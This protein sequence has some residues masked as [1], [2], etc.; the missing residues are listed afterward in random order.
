LYIRRVAEP[1]KDAP[2]PR[3]LGR[4]RRSSEAR[5]AQLLDAAYDV[6]AAGGPP[7]GGMADVAAAAGVSAGL[8]YHY[9]PSGRAELIEALARRLLDE[10]CDRVEVAASL[11]FSALGRLEQA[12]A[13]LVG[14]LVDRPVAY[15][16]LF[17]GT[18]TGGDGELSR[19]AR[20][21]LVTLFTTHLA[22]SARPAD[23]L[24]E[25]GTDLLDRVLADLRRCLAGELEPEAA[26]R[27]GCRR[28]RRAFA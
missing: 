13:G 28:A 6:L 23:E 17:D 1:A 25:R 5:R 24:V 9:F 16:L 12:L 7:D 15:R 19:L 22:D 10:L 26:W 3:S 8:L 21:R 27:S 18:G 14:Y 2:G 20:V 11:P 4:V